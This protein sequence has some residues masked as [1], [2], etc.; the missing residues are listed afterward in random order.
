MSAWG[1][2][3]YLVSDKCHSPGLGPWF[4]PSEKKRSHLGFPHPSSKQPS[5]KYQAS[6]PSTAPACACACALSQQR[7]PK[8]TASRQAHKNSPVP[9]LGCVG[10]T[11]FQ[12]KVRFHSP[13]LW[14]TALCPFLNCLRYPSI[15][16]GAIVGAHAR[17]QPGA[18]YLRREMKEKAGRRCLPVESRLEA[19]R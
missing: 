18:V 1:A 14:S 13:F 16:E 3:S 10:W 2:W 8:Q 4:M 6:M 17:P 9:R 12:F 7:A 5:R 19:S 15:L 11:S